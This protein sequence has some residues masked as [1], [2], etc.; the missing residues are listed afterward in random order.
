MTTAPGNLDRFS[1]FSGLYDAV[2]PEPPRALAG[3]LAGYAG[4]ARPSVV[5]L[6]S[7]T[8]LSSRWASIWAG[9]V[10]GVEPN[11]DMRAVAERRPAPGV[12]YRPGLSQ[13]TGLPRASADVVLVVQA[14]HWMDPVPTL[15]EVRRIL[16]PGGVVAVVDADWP[17]VA[18]CARAERAWL[19]LDRRFRVFEDRM[20]AGQEGAELRRPVGEEPLGRGTMDLADGHGDRHRA[21][22]VRS[23]SKSGHLGRLASSGHFAFTREVV[24]HQA[25]DGGA[26]RFVAL[27]R[28]QGTYQQ[29]SRAGLSDRDLGMERF[30][31][32]V[33]AGWEGAPVP[34]RLAISWRARLGVTA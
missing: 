33:G 22:G 16:R 7:G 23:W 30:Q 27:M 32:E 28:S 6:G 10:T 21:G 17:P 13:R 3:L 12:T 20:A 11:D 4:S 34:L 24:F 31:L 9:S 25:I 19:D 2:R 26:E 1:G 18:G 14:M 5:D 8:G 29:L 15:A